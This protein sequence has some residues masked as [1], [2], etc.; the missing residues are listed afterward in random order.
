MKGGRVLVATWVA[1]IAIISYRSFHNGEGMPAPR[2]LFAANIVWSVLSLLALA[3]EELANVLSV[4]T[5]L[6]L[7]MTDSSI[8]GA[9]GTAASSQ[10]ASASP[11]IGNVVAGT[12]VTPRSQGGQTA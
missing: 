7:V 8:L 4:G 11:A 5:L 9:A 10:A 2:S 1:G 3:S 12:N 6:G